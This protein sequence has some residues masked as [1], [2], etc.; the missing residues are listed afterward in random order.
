MTYIDIQIIWRALKRYNETAVVG[1]T[2]NWYSMANCRGKDFV[3]VKVILS[4]STRD[5]SSRKIEYQTE[6]ARQNA[7]VLNKY[8]IPLRA[9]H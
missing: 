8:W 4:L 9:I 1:I 3:D 6:N 5:L 2:A 7:G